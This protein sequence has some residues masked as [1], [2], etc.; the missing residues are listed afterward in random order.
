MY[1]LIL[2]TAMSSGQDVAPAPRSNPAPAAMGYGCGAPLAGCYGSGCYGSCSGSC[3]GSGCYGS[4]HGCYGSC[5]GA[6]MG[7]FGHHKTS[8]HGCTG[9]SCNGWNCFGSCLGS[10]FGSCFGSCHGSCF[11]SGSCYGS[12]FGSSW[13]PAATLQGY[14]ASYYANPWAVYGTVNRPA[15]VIV[16]VASDAKAG[17]VKPMDKPTAPAPKEGK[18]GMGAS[19]KF[20]LPVDARLYVDGRITMIGGTER[21]F[22]TP[23]LVEGQKFYYDVRAELVVDGK[24]V[25]EEKRVIVAAGATVTESFEKLIAAADGKSA[26]VAGK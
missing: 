10:C 5:H 18:E 26:V 12:C 9:Y 22:T 23:P 6:R 20:R 7:L 17:E 19:L 1:G 25:V 24:P 21:T 3:Y 13:A 11:G 4:C 14:G 2:L 16:P 15:V 8:C